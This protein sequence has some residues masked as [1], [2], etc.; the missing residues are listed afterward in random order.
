M[1]TLTSLG[2]AIPDDI[3]IVGIDDV[4]FAGLLH[5]PLTTFRQPCQSIGAAALMVMFTR[6]A[7]PNLPS[8]HIMLDFKLVVRQSCGTYLNSA[9]PVAKPSG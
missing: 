6:I 2:V 5:P 1:S 9:N 3:R 4:S 7:D 8:R